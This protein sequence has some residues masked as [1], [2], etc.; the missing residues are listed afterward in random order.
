M[1]VETL[2]WIVLESHIAWL[3]L[4]VKQIYESYGIIIS[5]VRLSCEVTA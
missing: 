2:L 3:N 4:E 1:I 5:G